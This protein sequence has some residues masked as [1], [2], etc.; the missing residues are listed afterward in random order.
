MNAGG[1]ASEI[2]PKAV[3]VVTGIAALSTPENSVK[4]LRS[5]CPRNCTG[6]SGKSIFSVSGRL[7]SASFSRSSPGMPPMA[8][9][10][11]RRPRVG[12][13]EPPTGSAPPGNI[14]GSDNSRPEPRMVIGPGMTCRWRTAT[15][16]TAECRVAPPREI[17]RR[18]DGAPVPGRRQWAGTRR[19]HLLKRGPTCGKELSAGRVVGYV[20]HS[21][22]E[23]AGAPTLSVRFFAPL[24]TVLPGGVDR[25]SGAER[26]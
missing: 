22:P 2:W 16:R 10:A 7:P 17:A 3:T 25:D 19:T 1:R 26:Q 14:T 8:H 18:S 24:R 4:P 6:G 23:R 13:I 12:G 20:T 21:I 15:G 11:P 5:S 9:L